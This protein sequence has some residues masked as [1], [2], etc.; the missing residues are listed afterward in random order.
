MAA[1]PYV[2]KLGAATYK[3]IVKEEKKANVDNMVAFLY[4][5]KM[6]APLHNFIVKEE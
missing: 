1:V 5:Q 3:D 2:L 6:D 4:A